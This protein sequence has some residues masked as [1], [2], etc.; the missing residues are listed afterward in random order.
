M[1]AK[2]VFRRKEGSQW[3]FYYTGE[4][5]MSIDKNYFGLLSVL[6]NLKDSEIASAELESDN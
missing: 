1:G 5:C 4:N 2:L 6:Y 3:L